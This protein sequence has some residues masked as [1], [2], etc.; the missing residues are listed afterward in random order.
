MTVEKYRVVITFCDDVVMRHDYDAQDVRAATN[1][2]SGVLAD[3]IV[4]DSQETHIRNVQLHALDD[5]DETIRSIDSG[6]FP[7][8]DREEVKTDG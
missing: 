8:K 3:A 7:C 5:N 1:E 6:D 4:P 2:Y